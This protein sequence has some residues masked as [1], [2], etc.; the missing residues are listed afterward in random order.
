LAI[1]LLFLLGLFAYSS[2]R[3]VGNESPRFETE[4]VPILE[5]NCVRCHNS[6]A[7]KAELDLSTPQGLF[8]GG[9][10]GE[11]IVTG[12]ADASL[13]YEYVHDGSMPP[14]EDRRLS[15]KDIETIRHWINARTPFVESVD[16]EELSAAGEVSNH[17][18][19]PLML[20]RCAA[21]HG[22]R[23]QQGGL[24][25]R[26]KASML[27]GGES[28]PAIV[29]GSP[30]ESL[31]LKRIHAVEMPPRDQLILAGVKP[32]TIGEIEK[33]T[34]WIE[35][36]AP[37]VRVDPDVASSAGDP[38]VSDDDR[39]FWS[40]QP[41]RDVNVPNVNHS[42][43]SNPIDAFVI[44]RLLLQQLALAEA[45]DKST[46]MRRAY[47]DLT[48]LPP[49][50][51]EVKA[52]MAD[53][54]PQAYRR[55]I[56][57]LLA[58]PRYGER[59]GQ[60]WLDAAGYADSEGKRSADPIRPHAYKYRDY[61]IRSFNND[62]PYDRFLLE[63]IAG[64]ELVDY[65]NAPQMTR[66]LVDNLVATGF[67]RMAPDGTG[68]DVVNFVP[69]RLEVIADEIDVFGSTVMGLTLKCARCH[70][71]KYDPIPH[72]DYYR[73]VA[74]F[75]GAFD[76]HDWLKPA[77]VPGQTKVTRPGRVLPFATE[78]EIVSLNRRN[79]Q[80]DADIARQRAQLAE[81]A[82]SIRRDHLEEQL[83][84]L[85][86]VLHDDLRTVLF[87]PVEE[88]NEVQQDLFN[89]FEK[90]LWISDEQLK[91]H[92]RYK[93]VELEANRLIKSLESEK[94]DAPQIRALWDRGA[95][96]PTYIYRRGEY[97]QPTRLVGPGVPSALTDGKT[98]FVVKSPWSGANKSGRRLA[99]AEWLIEPDHP[100][101]ARV[102][103]NRIWKH[104]FGRGIVKSVD[105][106]GKLGTPPTHPE[107]L[108][109]LARRFV[110]EG[111]SIK[112]MHR[113]IMTSAV[114]QQ[115]SHVDEDLQRADPENQ[116]LARMPLRRMDAEQVRDSLLFVSGMLDER[117][118]GRPDSV[119]V[120]GDGLITSI[121]SKSSW[122]RSVYVR[123]RRKEMPTI[124]ETFDLPQMNPA[125]QHRPTSTVA[126][127]A[128][129]LINNSAVRELSI[130][131]AR[132]ISQQT[133]DPYSQVE[134]AYL[135]ALSRLPN[136]EERA[137]SAQTLAALTELLGDRLESDQ[138]EQAAEQALAV[139]CH[140]LINSAAFLY[141]D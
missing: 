63:Q 33:M 46:L 90:R 108:D 15:E 101:T 71:H 119:E 35:L 55:L 97:T 76:E 22:L 62:K 137:A 127:Q 72:R 86:A 123:H 53:D 129:F 131:S 5:A 115:S 39:Q 25:L 29:L 37:E 48:G 114:Y 92:E 56:D 107:L 49:T 16:L 66:E 134:R 74:V 38:L 19:E 117:P 18:I 140:T 14:E 121:G 44:R 94:G 64:D 91:R 60:F 88:R 118:F 69:E 141:I 61:V 2:S 98:P 7:R 83:S 34:R 104:H 27:K 95:P 112:A 133:S 80:I 23:Q 110:Q 105:N 41:P 87:T 20:L 135:T 77:F 10:S 120:G 82:E 21:C 109:W 47:F 136:D 102:M 93:R 122:R 17:E 138:V 43:I 68:S 45:A 130:H 1:H 36:G 126:Q 8:R 99:L 132:R 9:E 70:S 4:I 79:E 31:L 28:G 81:L 89:K 113:R 13:L 139:V 67:L 52:Y 58:S 54:D 75:K 84:D 128:L 73:L 100:L 42:R 50:A 32:M 103:V 65:E 26:T 57:R 3:A 51:A 78:E 106:F 116:W 124:L 96:S 12:D 111:W 59:W 11:S 6:E 125:C 40:F 30:A 85:P 24:D